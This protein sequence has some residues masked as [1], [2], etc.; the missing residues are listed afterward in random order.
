MGVT[1]A[2]VT[3]HESTPVRDYGK[4]RSYAGPV[5]VDG[6]GLCVA[7]EGLIEDEYGS[8]VGACG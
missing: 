6:R 3:G 5:Y 7:W 8:G 4:F 1:L 2:E